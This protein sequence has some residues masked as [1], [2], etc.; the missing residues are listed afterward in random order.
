MDILLLQKYRDILLKQYTEGLDIL[1]NMTVKDKNYQTIVVNI[2]NASNIAFQ[3]G[4]E[5]DKQLKAIELDKQA[6]LK[7]KKTKKASKKSE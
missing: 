5:V 1:A 2:N 7:E 3:L 4:A 6:V